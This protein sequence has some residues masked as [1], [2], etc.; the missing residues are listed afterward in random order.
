MPWGAPITTSTADATGTTRLALPN[1]VYVVLAGN[2]ALRLL[3]K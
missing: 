2:Q 1:G 3:V